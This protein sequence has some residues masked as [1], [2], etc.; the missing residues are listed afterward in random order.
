MFEISMNWF[1]QI[2]F[3]NKPI[4]WL[5]LSMNPNISWEIVSS[6]PE[7]PWRWHGLIRILSMSKILKVL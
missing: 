5:G 7:K 1:Q 6:N 4:Y 3:E 2:I